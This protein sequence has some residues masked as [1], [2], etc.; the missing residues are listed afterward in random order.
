MPN[1]PQWQVDFSFQ[2]ISLII[3]GSCDHKWYL[4]REWILILRTE[5]HMLPN[6]NK[7]FWSM[8]RMNTEPSIDICPSLSLNEYRV[9]ISSSHQQLRDLVNHLWIDMISQL[10]LQNFYMLKLWLKWDPDEVMAHYSYWQPQG[11]IWIHQLNQQSTGFNMFKILMIIIP[12]SLVLA[13]HFAY[14][15]SP[16]GGVNK[17]KC[18]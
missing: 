10:T 1:L 5:V 16:T 9:T 11:S 14:W 4:K 17:I 15:I 18:S 6:T 3:S 8:W 12:T 7:R 2:H 13:E